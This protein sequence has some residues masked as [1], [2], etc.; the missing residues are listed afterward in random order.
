MLD[1]MQTVGTLDVMAIIGRA[2]LA[3]S[4]KRNY[5]AAVAGYVAAGGDLSDAEAVANYA[6][7]LSDGTKQQFKAGLTLVWNARLD[8]LKGQAHPDNVDVIQAAAYRVEALRSAIKTSTP[9]GQKAHTWLSQAQVKALLDSCGGDLQGQRDRLAL[10]LLV[11]AGL[12][13]AEAVALTFD[14]LVYKPVGDRFRCVLAITGKGAKRRE[15]PI[16]DAL[17]RAIDEWGQVVGHQGRVLRSFDQRRELTDSLSGVGL[18]GI[19]QK[20]GEAIGKPELAPHDLRR[21][22]AQLGYE[23]GIPLTQVSKLLGHASV[24]TTQRYLNL[25]LDLEMTISD[26][27][28][29]EA[30]S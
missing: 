14:D 8:W 3:E 10:G 24:A 17:A 18:F 5:R 25:D 27:I 1:A 11:A 15:V 28:P 6:D 21:T 9:Q 30:G 26:F 20:A 23:A 22:Y 19:V 13:R 2:N 29:F 7:G 4:T 12:R 16:S